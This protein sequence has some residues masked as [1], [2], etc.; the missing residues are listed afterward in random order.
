ML[1]RSQS[2]EFGFLVLSPRFSVS[3]SPAFCLGPET[4]VFEFLEL[5]L[6]LAGS[7]FLELCLDLGSFAS[8]SLQFSSDL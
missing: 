1:S 6:G 5:C 8:G 7:V 4:A 3:G 2:S